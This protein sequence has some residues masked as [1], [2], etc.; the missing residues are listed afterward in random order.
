[1]LINGFTKI[2]GL[3]GDPIGHTLSPLMHNAAFRDL[4]INCVYLPFHV[5]K[6]ELRHALKSLDLLGITGVNL[7]IPHK[8]GALKYVDKLDKQAELIGA[9]NTIKLDSGKIKGYNTDGLG[10][11]EALKKECKFD[12][13]QK[14]ILVLGAGGAARAVCISLAINKAKKIIISNRTYDKAKKLVQYLDKKLKYRAICISLDKKKLENIASD[15]DLV[16]NCTSVGL[17]DPG[18][19]ILKKSFFKK[20]LKLKLVYDLICSKKQ[21]NLLKD[22][23]QF[24]IKAS[25][26]I[27]MLVYQGALSFEIWTGRKPK[28]EIMKRALQNR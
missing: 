28:L 1:M 20:A 3:F 21:T 17:I 22:A 11:I 18:T 24:G 15:I 25:N 7:T 10:F 8:V 4:E 19:R 26:G 14:T 16:V 27:G 9:V 5:K 12:P 6:E 2:V 23:G 13:R